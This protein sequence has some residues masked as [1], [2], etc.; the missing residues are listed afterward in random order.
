MD[1]E[2][3]YFNKIDE[4]YITHYFKFKENFFNDSIRNLYFRASTINEIF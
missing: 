3:K 2:I 4:V 1:K